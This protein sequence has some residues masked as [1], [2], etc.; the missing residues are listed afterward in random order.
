MIRVLLIEDSRTVGAY[1]EA[2]LGAEPDIEVLPSAM[3]GASGIEAA[4]ARCPDVILM[5]LEL[6]GVDGISAIEQI[7]ASDPRPIV[8]LSAHL[9][10]PGRDRAFESL[11]AGAVEVLAKP[12]GLSSREVEGF[13]SKL[14]QTV[15]L[16][17][18]ARVVGRWGRRRRGAGSGIELGSLPAFKPAPRGAKG[19]L[20]TATAGASGPQIA[21]I[22]GST[23]AP[24]VL[25]HLLRAI[26]P[27]SLIPIV[28]AQHTIPGFEEALAQWLRGTGHAVDVVQEA[29]ALGPGRVAIASADRHVV[30]RP[31]R[32]EHAPVVGGGPS[33]SADVLFG[34]AAEAYGSSAIALLLSGMGSDG[35][36][37]LLELRKRGATTI[38]QRADTCVIDG[39]PGAARAVGA[40]LWD[41]TPDE[42]GDA[43]R[44]AASAAARAL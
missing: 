26:K 13:R 30:V 15:R 10:A 16:M 7:M 4:R 19:A 25:E 22:A 41:L 3:D 5:D 31:G 18:G 12:W 20:L 34:S 2:V 36:I 8:V 23:G 6:P 39:M 43:L 40:G 9:E 35:A 28:I 42:M 33:P 38:T 44:R 24:P 11:E 37:G 32:L 27:P 21:I 14:L 17:S 29:G 1:V